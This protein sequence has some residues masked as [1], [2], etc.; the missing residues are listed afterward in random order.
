MRSAARHHA[1]P[2]R[3]AQPIGVMRRAEQ[4][5]QLMYV[6][7]TSCRCGAGLQQVRLTVGNLNVVVYRTCPTKQVTS[8][9]QAPDYSGRFV[10]NTKAV[11]VKWVLRVTPLSRTEVRTVTSWKTWDV[12]PAKYLISK[13]GEWKMCIEDISK[14]LIRSWIPN[15][16]ERERSRYASTW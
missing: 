4:C 12:R 16:Y 15:A 10:C 13:L 3:P 6:Y 11:T 1:I 5:R 9:T 14:L 2:P 8:S 7:T